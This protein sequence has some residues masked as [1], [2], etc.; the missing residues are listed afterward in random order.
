[1]KPTRSDK[2]RESRFEI[3]AGATVGLHKRGRSVQATTVNM[4]GCGALLK[5]PDP[6]DLLVGDTVMCDFHITKES[7]EKLPCWAEGT[8]VRV[9]DALVAL[10]F[11]AGGWTRAKAAVI[12]PEKKR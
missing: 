7:G 1:M 4:S 10:H 5:F 8:V 12:P 11:H 6:V 9:E 3:E 2:R